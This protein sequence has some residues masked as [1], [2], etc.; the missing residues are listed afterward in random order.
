MRLAAAALAAALAVL[1][2]GSSAQSIEAPAAIIP[3]EDIPLRVTGLSPGESVTLVTERLHPPFRPR[4]MRSET[5][6]VADA[7]GVATP[8]DPS[9]PFWSLQPAAGPVEGLQ[10]DRIRLS[11]AGRKVA[12]EIRV[13]PPDTG[14]G[15]TPVPGFPGARLHRPAG[16]VGTLPVI[17]TLG[18]SEGNAGLGLAAARRL[19]RAG[20]ATVSFPYV[21]PDTGEGQQL[22]GLPQRVSAIPIDRLDQL[23]DWIATR[24]DLDPGR[25]GLWGASKGAEY[26][27]LA[28]VRFGWVQATAAIAPTDVSWAAFGGSLGDDDGPGFTYRGAPIPHVPYAGL[29]RLRRTGSGTLREVHEAG[30]AAH[31]ERARSARIAVEAIEGALLVAGGGA[32]RSWPAGPAVQAIAEARQRAGRPV[33]A[34]SFPEAGHALSGDAWSPATAADAAARARIWAETLG[35]FRKALLP[36]HTTSGRNGTETSA[37]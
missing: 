16:I 3:G 24:P 4:P 34:L 13:L 8:T 11:L 18:G 7:L 19:A 6:I 23:R 37:R 29:D 17:I 31:P 2:G 32:D 12:S 35:F 33:A 25:I 26:A 27:L 15:E 10:T 14:I 1:A 5:R 22:P 30:R 36:A 28:A 9:R 21:S 20:F